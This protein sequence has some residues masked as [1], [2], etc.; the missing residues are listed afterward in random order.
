MKNCIYF[1]TAYWYKVG[2]NETNKGV[3]ETATSYRVST[4]KKISFYWLIT[5]KSSHI[6]NN[7]TTG[8]YENFSRRIDKIPLDY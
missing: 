7:E 5:S 4:K 2:T 6:G 8:P 1:R 3:Q